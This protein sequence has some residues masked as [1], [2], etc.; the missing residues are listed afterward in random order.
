LP[1]PEEAAQVMSGSELVEGTIVGFSDSGARPKAYAVVE[2]IQRNTFVVP[3]E[4][5]QPAEVVGGRD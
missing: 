4:R 1:S 2:I 3:V 5:L